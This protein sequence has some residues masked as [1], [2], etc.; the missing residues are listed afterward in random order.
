MRSRHAASALVLLL[1]VGCQSA[2]L[3]ATLSPQPATD[4]TVPTQIP[5]TLAPTEI[6]TAVANELVWPTYVAPTLAP[7]PLSENEMIPVVPMIPIS[8][9]APVALTAHDHLYFSLPADE[10]DIN[11]SMPSQRYGT[12]QEGTE[13]DAHLGLDFS[14]NTGTPVLAA[15]PGTVVWASYGLLFNSEFYI[16]DPYGISVVIRHDFGYD[17][18]RLFTIYAHLSEA[19]V[20]VGEYV[21]RGEVIARSGSTGQSTGPHLHFEVRLGTN[22]IYFTRNPELW[23]ASEDRGVLAG[24]LTTTRDALL[25]NRLVEITSRETGQ[26][27]TMYTYATEFRLLPDDYYDENFVLG[28]L[29]AGTYEIAVPYL[30]VWQRVDVEIKPGMVTYF[31][32]RGTEGY[33]FDPPAIPALGFVPGD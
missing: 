14:M 27:W 3:S 17:G 30:G 28:D 5:T 8:F 33:N 7:F 29:P 32:F 19:N 1:L 16:D 6:P 26:R 18:E 4:T 9:S 22:T 10:R 13:A 11:N 20:E 2:T 23:I 24:H 15:A 12:V 21:E 31:R 25:F